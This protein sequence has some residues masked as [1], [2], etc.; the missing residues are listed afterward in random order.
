MDLIQ[1]MILMI[2]MTLPGSPQMQ[3]QIL[4]LS[5]QVFLY[6]HKDTT[7]KEHN[8]RPHANAHRQIQILTLG[9]QFL[10]ITTTTKEPQ[11]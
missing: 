6:L 8:L 2:V 3:I 4:T 5:N 7:S 9:N 1:M 11:P 10:Y